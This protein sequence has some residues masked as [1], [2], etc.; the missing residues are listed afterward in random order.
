MEDFKKTHK[1]WRNFL[2]FAVLVVLLLIGGLNFY[3]SWSRTK[4]VNNE[5]SQLQ[6]EIK[7]LEK[8][9]KEFQELIEYFNSDAY[10]EERARLDLGLKKDGEKVAVI[11]KGNETA[12][13]RSQETQTKNRSNLTNPQKWWDYF[14]N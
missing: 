11:P 7:N 10:I 6:E 12:D 1:K 13:T 3:Q 9:N 4:E 8:N 14:F 5:I 2:I